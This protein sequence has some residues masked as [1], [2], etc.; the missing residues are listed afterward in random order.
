MAGL[1]IWPFL[2]NFVK[3]IISLWHGK[4]KETRET[5][6]SDRSHRTLCVVVPPTVYL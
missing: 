3:V 6:L 1:F 5:W 4:I 2:F